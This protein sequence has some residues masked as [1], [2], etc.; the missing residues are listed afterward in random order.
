VSFAAITLFVAS[1]RV[2]IVYF[3]IDSV[4]KLLVIPTYMA[5]TLFRQCSGWN[6]SVGSQQKGQGYTP[7]LSSKV[8][9]VRLTFVIIA[10]RQLNLLS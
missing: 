4:R 8:G 10:Q 2:F 6:A 3:V 9:Q 7:T 1:Q 5:S